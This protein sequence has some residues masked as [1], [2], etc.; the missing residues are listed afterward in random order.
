[1]P[2]AYAE[3]DRSRLEVAPLGERVHDL[4][5]RVIA[6]LAPAAEVAS[7][8]R[9]V[10]RGIEAAGRASK[11]LMM[12]AHVLRAGVQ[13]YLIDL[14]ERGLDDCIA[15]NG[16]GVVH[17]FELALIGATTE[18]VARYIRDGRFGLWRETGRIN[19]IVAEGA[20]Q[21][22]G[23]GEAVGRVIEEERFPHRDVSV[24]GAAYR[25]GV[26]ATVHVGIGYDIVHEHPNCDGAAYGVTSYTDFLRF[27]AV[28]ERLEGGVVMSFGSPVMA[29]E[30]F[31]KAL[32]MVRNAG[33]SAGRRIARF[34]ALVCD[35]VDLPRDFREEP[36]ADQPGYY[37]RPWKTL[38]VR[39][40][41]D[42]G[43]SFYH[44]GRHAQTVPMLWT[45]LCGA[46]AGRRSP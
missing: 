7:V 35:L 14:L 2:K 16:A 23:L 3:F 5:E 13:R 40:V 34:T 4:S 21:G 24:L 41:S 28:V 37:F 36:A 19:D 20:Q 45:A 32:A 17:D 25:L 8:F 1:M 31:L 42:G 29:P 12:G 10:A 27:A 26:P 15:M 43:E 6:P 44:K 39:T 33:R 30:V 46:R 11:I 18:S 38:L 9:D 22:L